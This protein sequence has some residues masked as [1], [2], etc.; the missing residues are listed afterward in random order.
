MGLVAPKGLP[1]LVL[2]KLF[3]A[4]KRAFEDPSFQEFMAKLYLPTV[5]KDSEAFK[6]MVFKDFDSQGRVLKELGL[7]K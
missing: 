2:K 4:F 6:E 7:I 5:F 1:P 3:D